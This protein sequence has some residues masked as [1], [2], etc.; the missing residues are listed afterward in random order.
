MYYKGGKTG[1][2]VEYRML[3]DSLYKGIVQTPYHCTKRLTSTFEEE[4][5]ICGTVNHR[6]V[7]HDVQN[8]LSTV[9][10]PQICVHC[11]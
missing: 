8:L 3:V 5:T 10:I 6:T 4:G 7:S 1:E 2:R 11:I 9:Y